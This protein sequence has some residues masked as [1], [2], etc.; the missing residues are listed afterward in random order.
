MS[1]SSSH[2][3]DQTELELSVV[4]PCLDEADT[5]ATC[6]RKAKD[7][8]ARAGV[9]AE[10][11]IAD[12]GSS[13]GSIEIAE[14]AGARV[15]HVR[16]R[17][18]GH[19]LQ[20]GIQA[21]RGK[22]VI[23]GDADDS[24][25]FQEIPKFVSKL[26]E[27][28][29]LVQG[30]R[31]PDGGG[32]VMPGA[33]PFLHRWWGNP[34]L[35]F[36]SRWWFRANVNDIYSGFRGFTKDLYERLDQQATGMEF[37]TEMIIKASLFHANVT[38]VPITLHPDGRKS[39]PPHLKTFRDGWR[40]LRFY[41]LFTPRWLFLMPGLFLIVAGLIG[42]GVALPAVT[43]KGVTF[44]VHTLLFASLAIVCGYQSIAFAFL[45]KFFA[46]RCN[47]QPETPR[48][49]TLFSV[50][51]LERGLISSAILLVGGLTLLGF[52]VNKWRVS[53][54]GHLDYSSTMRVV[55]PGAMLTSLGI[56]NV[57]SSFFLSILGLLRK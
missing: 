48:L 28:F 25:D 4:M 15:I 34:M 55:I 2:R 33:M 49:R 41:L 44:D 37:A 20:A 11:I 56:Q 27:G 52:A 30:C 17:G 54:F 39:H 6:I 7:G 12:N 50:V 29:E 51:T 36:L 19:A 47:L 38:Q 14:G 3:E 32:T 8:I 35:T 22:Y 57:F 31:L 23:M 21:A 18:Y 13:D 1:D 42:Y 24:Y 10:I 5:L 43:F 40:T 26:R 46:V 9:R 53:H 16:E 45:S